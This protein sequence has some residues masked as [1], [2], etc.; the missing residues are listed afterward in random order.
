M[1]RQ[2]SLMASSGVWYGQ[3][4]GSA[5]GSTIFPPATRV[6]ATICDEGEV[7]VAGR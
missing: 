7:L 6:M 1:T 4:S 2:P 3:S 5:A